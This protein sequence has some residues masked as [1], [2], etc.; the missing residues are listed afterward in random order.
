MEKF[1][2][3][4]AGNG[5]IGSAAARHIAYGGAPLLVLGPD[6]PADWKKH[7]GVFSSHYDSGRITRTLDSDYVWGL[8]ADRSIKRYRQIEEE[9]GVRFANMVGCLKVV[10]DN[11]WGRKYIAANEAVGKRLGSD[12]EKLSRADLN[13][14]F[15]YLNFPKNTIG[16]FERSTAGFIDPRE[17]KKAQNVIAEKHGAAIC[18][19]TVVNRSGVAAPANGGMHLMTDTGREFQVEKLLVTAG[20]FSNLFNL[21]PRQLSLTVR[22]ETTVLAEVLGPA[23]N[24][25]WPG[26]F[27]PV[28]PHGPA[29]L[30]HPL[31]EMPS[32]IWFLEENAISSYVYLVPPV[33]YPDGK[34]RI[35][36]GGDSEREHTFTDLHRM[37]EWFHGEGG[38]E[39]RRVFTE[40]LESLL[41]D[42]KFLSWQSKPCVITDTVTERPYIGKVSDNIYV[43][44]GGCGAAAKSSD[45]IG[46]LGAEL[47]LN[48]RII[49][50]AYPQSAFKVI[51]EDMEPGE[52]PGSVRS[53]HF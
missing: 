23:V 46:R 6:E 52:V 39:T 49:D 12:F 34:F 36:I 27:G 44:T 4:I 11:E 13:R 33:M 26:V 10:P 18:R 5:L 17:L 42:V 20:A 7:N 50:D 14:Y 40:S 30:P 3:A 28:R 24:P 1:K 16:L 41:P 43:A 25:D 51:S 35:K 53:F 22:A 15:P 21:S 48:E 47:M 29:N 2:Y 45:E 31:R 38:E 37:A 8:L 9:S 32:V 19:E